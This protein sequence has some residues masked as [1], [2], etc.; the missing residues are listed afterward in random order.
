MGPPSQSLGPFEEL[1]PKKI[2]RFWP[3]TRLLR[4]KASKDASAPLAQGPKRTQGRAVGYAPLQSGVNSDQWPFP[5]FGPFPQNGQP[6]HIPT[7]EA[8]KWRMQTLG[9]ATCA[10]SDRVSTGTS[11]LEFAP[12]SWWSR[13]A[14]GFATTRCKVRDLGFGVVSK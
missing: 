3:V 1:C 2:N 4:A 5:L 6:N 13:C 10:R 12:S 7:L 9:F 11:S 8:F 14:R